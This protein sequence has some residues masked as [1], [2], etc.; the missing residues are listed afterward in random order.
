M[1]SLISRYTKISLVPNQQA[2]D[3]LASN[4]HLEGLTPEL[5]RAHWLKQKLENGIVAK[6][7]LFTCTIFATSMV[8]GDGVLTPLIS[9]N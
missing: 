1:Y 8:M 9:G 5:K 4:G 3:A 6:I 2:E 7:L